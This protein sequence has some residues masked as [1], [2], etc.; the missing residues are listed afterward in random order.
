[1]QQRTN[2]L[3][4]RTNNSAEAWRRGI[5]STVQCQHFTLWI[6]INNLKNEEHYVYYQLVKLN[7]GE[8]MEPNKKYVNYSMRLRNL[9][10][11]LLPT[12]LQQLSGHLL[13]IYY[14]CCFAYF[15]KLVFFCCIFFI[16]III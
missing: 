7:A 1:M 13:I 10:Q 12:S 8:K 6:F 2:D 14:L 5:D 15:F 4:M 3:L 9:I 16:M 11:N